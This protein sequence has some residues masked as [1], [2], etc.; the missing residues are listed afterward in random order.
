MKG[1][2]TDNKLLLAPGACTL[3]EQIHLF[4]FITLWKFNARNLDIIQAISL[5][6]VR[7]F[8]MHMIVVMLWSTMVIAEGIL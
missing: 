8:K 7:A 5:A 1:N 3:D 6:T 4:H 2:P